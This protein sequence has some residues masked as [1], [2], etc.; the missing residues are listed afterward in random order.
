MKRDRANRIKGFAIDMQSYE[1][2]LSPHLLPGNHRQMIERI[3]L[4]ASD[5][6]RIASTYALNYAS[7]PYPPQIDRCKSKDRRS[8]TRTDVVGSWGCKAQ[9]SLVIPISPTTFP[10]KK[11]VSYSLHAPTS[12]NGKSDGASI[13]LFDEA[14]LNQKNHS[15]FAFFT[16]NLIIIYTFISKYI[17]SSLHTIIMDVQR[18]G[19]PTILCRGIDGQR[20]TSCIIFKASGWP[21]SEG[22]QKKDGDRP[23][24]GKPT[25]P[26]PEKPKPEREGDKGKRKGKSPRTEQ[27][28][29]KTMQKSRRSIYRPVAVPGY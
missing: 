20:T 8:K 16:T 18:Y 4:Q 28:V 7:P 5:V 22:D 10:S 3:N 13:E 23:E 26:K 17:S 12:Y 11:F 9:S 2:L 1:A 14:A 29:P 24:P 21:I 25:K 15:R 6:A 19:H 27:L